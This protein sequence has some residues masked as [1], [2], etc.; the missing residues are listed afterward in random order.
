MRQLFDHPVIM[1]VVYFVLLSLATRLAVRYVRKGPELE[2]KDRQDFGIVLAAVLTLLGLIIGFTFSMATTRYDL[3][4]S[5]EEAEANAIG[6]EYVRADFLPA[7]DAARVRQLLRDY[8]AQRIL[9]YQPHSQSELQDIAAHRAQL[10]QQLW[11]TVAPAAAAQPTALTG[12]VAS[13]MNDVLNSQGYT[14]AAWLNR[15]PV[16]AWVLLLLLALL[17]NLMIVFSARTLHRRARVLLILP[18]V[19]SVSAMLLADIDSPRGGIIK[20]S[21]ENLRIVADSMH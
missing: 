21:A 15:I 1:G 8:T 5:Y 10:Q 19:V 3:R 11:S 14:H 7:A 9:Y 16:E 4:K 18:L 13:G 2:E 20:V 6:T 17:S 12:L